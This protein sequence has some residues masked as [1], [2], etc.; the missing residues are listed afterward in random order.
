MADDWFPL[1]LGF[2]AAALS[3]AMALAFG[4]WLAYLARRRRT[5]SLAWLPLSVSPV[6]LIAYCL[7]ATDFQW[8]TAALV[9]SLFGLPYVMRESRAA[10]E[11]LPAEYL[12]AARGL[13]A[14][15][16]RV[17]RSIA[18]PLAWRPILAAGA[19]VFA[20]V[21]ADCGVV[22][23]LARALRASERLPFWPLATLGAISLAVHYAGMRWD[24]GPEAS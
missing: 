21:G 1:W 7:A 9:A 23:I 22:L 14:S 17:F 24:R 13:G 2:R 20:T 3:T 16:W 8:P 6:L 11:A 10:F 15:E 5:A 12:N 19:F 4:P 18:A